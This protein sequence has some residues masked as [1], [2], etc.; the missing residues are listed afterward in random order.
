[1]DKSSAIFTMDNLTE[2][3]S[4]SESR[5]ARNIL[6][7]VVF[8]LY[9]FSRIPFPDG[10][11][12]NPELDMYR[13]QE[14]MK[15]QLSERDWQCNQCGK[16]F[17]T[18]ET[19]DLHMYNRHSSSLYTGINSTCLALF[20]PLLRCSV[21]HPDL[22]LGEQIFWDE[23]LCDDAQFRELGKQC[24]LVLEQCGAGAHD[25]N[26][27]LREWL[28]SAVCDHLSCDRYWEVPDTRVTTPFAQKFLIFVISV[29]GIIT[30]YI[31]VFIRLNAPPGYLRVSSLS[32]PYYFQSLN[33]D[34]SRVPEAD[35]TPP[36]V[37]TFSSKRRRR[38]S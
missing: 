31:V 24:E 32:S 35:A 7:E 3:C 14:L 17:Y 20:C 6:K 15:V 19:L 4:R 10:C 27:E 5:M 29:V 23:A 26:L 28:K 33:E 2:S 8:P 30:Y 13:L 36:V 34:K 25:K 21:F 37:G 11:P 9:E 22:A 12:W 1:M 38:V 16:R 18:E